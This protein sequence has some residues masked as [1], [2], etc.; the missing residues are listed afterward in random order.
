MGQALVPGPADQGAGEERAGAGREAE[1]LAG[2]GQERGPED[3]AEAGEGEDDA[4][5]EAAQ[6]ACLPGVVGRT[7]GFGMAALDPVVQLLGECE[8]VHDAVP[9]A[10]PVVRQSVG[11]QEGGYLVRVD[12][13]GYEVVQSGRELVYRIGLRPAGGGALPGNGRERAGARSGRHPDASAHQPAP[14]VATASYQGSRSSTVRVVRTRVARDG[15][16]ER[17]AR[18][19]PDDVRQIAGVGVQRLVQAGGR[20]VVLADAAAAVGRRGVDPVVLVGHLGFRT[21][22]AVHV[23]RI[24]GHGQCAAARRTLLR[25]TGVVGGGPLDAVVGEVAREVRVAVGLLRGE[26]TMTPPPGERSQ[27]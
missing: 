5:Q 25:L 20:G 3:V 15:L 9:L 19:L 11:L 8:G 7:L 18:L 27:E 21:R 16:P 14:S 23:H 26:V 6:Q 4:S 22:V 13:S 10:Y 24:A 1:A 2:T 12:G 17:G